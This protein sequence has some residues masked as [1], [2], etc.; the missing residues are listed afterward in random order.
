V[1]VKR[2]ALKSAELFAS[3]FI[4]AIA[5]SYIECGLMFAEARHR[6]DEA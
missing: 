2:I 3:C 6:R 4:V 5:M 1:S